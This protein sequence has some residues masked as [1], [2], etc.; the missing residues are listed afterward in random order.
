M[1]SLKINGLPFISRGRGCRRVGLTAWPSRPN[2]TSIFEL[3][4]ISLL[5]CLRIEI[6]IFKQLAP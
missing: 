2:L 5:R 1:M 4:I 3:V 6:E